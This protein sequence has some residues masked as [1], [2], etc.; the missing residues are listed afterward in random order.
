MNEEQLGCLRKDEKRRLRAGPYARA[1][2]R[3]QEKRHTIEIQT[4]MLANAAK[5]QD[6]ELVDFYTDDGY[7][8]E[9][10]ERPGIDRLLD[11]IERMGIDVV[12]ITEP[13]RLARE[14]FVQKLL[15]EEIKEKGA[16]VV[17]LSVPPA[18]NEDEELGLDVRGV[19]SAWERKKIKTRTFR[20]KIRKAK[21]GFIVGG[22]A[23]YGFKYVPGSRDMQSH[24]EP[25]EEQLRWVREMFR[26]CAWEG[27]SVDAIALRLMEFEVPTQSGNS[28][29]RRSTVHHILINETYAGRAHYLKRRSIPPKNPEKSVG[30]RRLKN[31]SREL[32]PKEEW[33]PIP[34]APVIDRETWD[35]AQLQLKRNARGSPRNTCHPYLLRGKTFCG[36]CGLP[37]YGSVSR[38][39]LRYQCSNRHYRSPLPKTCP[40]KSV[41]ASILDSVVWDVLSE[42][43]GSPDVFLSQL[44]ELQEDETKRLNYQGEEFERLEKKL[45]RLG[46]AE[47]RAAELYMSDEGMTLREYKEHVGKIRAEKESARKDKEELERTI[48]RKVDWERSKENM[49]FLD[50]YIASKLEKLNFEDKKRIVDLLVDRVVINGD[51]V[52]IE[53]AIR[54]METASVNSPRDVVIASNSSPSEVQNRMNSYKLVR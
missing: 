33:I 34:V 30:Y 6:W 12:P 48:R 5:D 24:Y 22:K 26:W 9:L 47:K 2:S 32:R 15:E 18:R 54:P 44:R 45:E 1:S 53:G 23:P 17:Y 25:I 27:L 3:E 49:R 52:R 29:W 8:G 21:R 11:E 40:A 37:C 36:L 19:V 16:K 20:G 10:L 51:K 7:S 31:T 46:K 4:E 38:S 35:R 50:A 43:L 28:V 13:D 39:K 14:F 41:D 42:V